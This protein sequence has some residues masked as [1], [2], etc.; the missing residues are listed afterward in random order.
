M[1]RRRTRVA[2][3]AGL[4]S[5][6]TDTNGHCGGFCPTLWQNPRL[7]PQVSEIGTAPIEVPRG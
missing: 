5:S 7:G 2:A 3:A 1:N 4:R 6:R